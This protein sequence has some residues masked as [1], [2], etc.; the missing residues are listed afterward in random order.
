MR[1]LA[2]SY[3]VTCSTNWTPTVLQSGSF[4][5]DKL[6]FQDPLAVGFA[7][8]G[9]RVRVSQ[10]RR[11]KGPFGVA[12][13]GRD[14][15]HHGIG[16][17]HIFRDP[18]GQLG[19]HPLGQAQD[20]RFGNV[21]IVRDIVARHDR[22]GRDILGA[23]FPQRLHNEAKDGRG[24][25][26]IGNVVLN[27]GVRRI[28]LAVAQKVAAFGDGQSD[29]FRCRWVLTVAPLTP[30][31][32][33]LYGKQSVMEATTRGVTPASLRSTTVYSMSWSCSACRL[34]V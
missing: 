30:Y 25:I 29:N 4:V 12:R 33:A 18:V 20:G 8:D 22:K 16:K 13:G 32:L 26:L 17:G 9:Y 3:G 34:A 1:I 24:R 10:F 23:P 2:F 27:G 11:D 5:V 6:V 28:K 14:A 31:D 21:A 19:V 7:K 15:V